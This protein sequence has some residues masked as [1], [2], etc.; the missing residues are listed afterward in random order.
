MT[1]L[2]T[3]RAAAG[4]IAVAVAG[5]AA[6]A[7]E[8]KLAHFGSTKYPL[9]VEV[10]VPLAEA[11]ND[12]TG[13]DMTMRVYPGGELGAGPAKQY[14]RAIDGVADITY[15]LP[16]YTAAQF[17]KTLLVEIPGVLPAG[18]VPTAEVWEDLALIEDEYRRVKLL[19]LWNAEPG[20]LMLR[21]KRVETLA[22]LAGLKIRV[23]SQNTGRVVE[24]WGATAVSM[25]ITEVYSSMETGVI[26][27]V[28]VD[29]STL[30]SFKLGEVT[31]YVVTGMQ[32][33][34]SMFML[35]MN[36]DSWADLDAETQAILTDLTGPELSEAGRVTM[37]NSATGAL[38]AWADA[39]GEIITLS[40]EAA[41]EFDAASASLAEEVIAELEADGVNAA[42]WAAALKD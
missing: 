19:A 6:Q 14:D 33:T 2:T 32:G 7:D 13:G 3:L 26:D 9:H 1:H 4:A 31:Q 29:T 12:A 34:N 39:G 22:D 10:F 41:A 8:L 30:S 18:A 28:L 36:R 23:P 21:D 38:K 20:V 24:S 5:L 37:S 17:R 15:A 16:G 11:F 25:P 42:A 40:P 27:G 35:V